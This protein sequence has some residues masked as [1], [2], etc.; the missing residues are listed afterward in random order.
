MRRNRF[1]LAIRVARQID[2][3]GGQRRF[4][5]IIDDFALARDDLQR[6]LKNL[7]VIEFNYFPGQILLSF[8]FLAALLGFALFFLLAA[9]FFAG[10]ANAD[11]L[12][13]QVHDVADGRLDGKV[14]SQI[15]INRFCLC[16]RF[17]N[18]ERTCHLAFVTP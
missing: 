14:A 13:R 10:Q 15:F 9:F 6:R 18:H 4:A 11:R 8:C 5:K 2:S 17:D 12:F 16:R 1:P 3:I 7:L